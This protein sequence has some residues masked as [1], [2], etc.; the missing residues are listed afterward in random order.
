L[1][2]PFFGADGASAV[3]R[4]SGLANTGPVID[5]QIC[6][7][8]SAFTGIVAQGL[9]D[10]GASTVCIDN[11]LAAKAGL[12]LIDQNASLEVVG[13]ARLNASVYLGRLVIPAL[14]FDELTR[15]HALSMSQPSSRVLLGRSFLKHFIVTYNGP[16]GMFHFERPFT[17][18]LE[19][20][21]QFD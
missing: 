5:I 6:A 2:R 15:F 11:R 18:F 16:E 8:G 10:T 4:Q 7:A 3:Q 12:K 21:T 19:D 1:R 9:I 17:P 20:E 13:G 14:E